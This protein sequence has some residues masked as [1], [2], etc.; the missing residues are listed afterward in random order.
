MSSGEPRLCLTRYLAEQRLS[1]AQEDTAP[2]ERP[3]GRGPGEREN[4]RRQVDIR[5]EPRVRAGAHTA[6]PQRERDANGLL[7]EEVFSGDPVLA[8]Q[9]SIV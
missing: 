4:G 5:D 2:L 3:P 9:E 6:S 1:G 8:E 7:V